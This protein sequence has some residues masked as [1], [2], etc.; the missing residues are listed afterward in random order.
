MIASMKIKISSINPLLLNNLAKKLILDSRLPR[1][2]LRPILINASS[3]QAYPQN[4]SKLTTFNFNTSNCLAIM[5][6]FMLI[7]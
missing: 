1:K 3:Q 2:P 6:P 4:I 5:V 7:I